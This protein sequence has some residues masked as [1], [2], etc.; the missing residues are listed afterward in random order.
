MPK[1]FKSLEVSSVKTLG[2]KQFEIT[3]PACTCSVAVPK[4]ANHG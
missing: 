4:S 3:E 2:D 1:T